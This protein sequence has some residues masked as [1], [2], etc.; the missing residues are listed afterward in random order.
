MMEGEAPAMAMALPASLPADSRQSS[1]PAQ[2]TGWRRL[3]RQQTAEAPP[4]KLPD[5]DRFWNEMSSQAHQSNP[6]HA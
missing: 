2:R 6:D 1:A 5:W 4:A 3:R